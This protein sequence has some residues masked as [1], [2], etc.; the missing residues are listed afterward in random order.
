MPALLFFCWTVCCTWSDGCAK[1]GMIPQIE[2][3]L[4]NWRKDRAIGGMTEKIREVIP[5]A[6]V[7]V[8]KFGG[9]IAHAGVMIE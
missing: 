6:G 5:Q 9:M 2:E 7:V 8:E 3:W 4:R 1:G